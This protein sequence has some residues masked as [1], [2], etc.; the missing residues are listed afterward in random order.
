MKNAAQIRQLLQSAIQKLQEDHC[1][2][3]TIDSMEEALALLPCETCK[4]TNQIE[5]QYFQE[6]SP[7]DL[8]CSKPCPDCNGEQ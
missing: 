4:G 8:P 3:D 6:L 2:F 5:S 7:G 1:C